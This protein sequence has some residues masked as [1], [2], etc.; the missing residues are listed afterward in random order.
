MKTIRISYPVADFQATVRYIAQNNP[1]GFEESHVDSA[2]RTSINQVINEIK[3]A[4]KNSTTDLVGIGV[5]YLGYNVTVDD[6]V[7][8]SNEL[9]Y[10]L[11]FSVTPAFVAFAEDYE[12]I[13]HVIEY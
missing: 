3:N 10:I 2:L 1:C 5:S 11:D 9:H 13:E 8:K 6:V 7:E 12:Y 4:V